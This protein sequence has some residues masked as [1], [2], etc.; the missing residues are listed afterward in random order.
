M[1]SLGSK[2]EGARLERMQS[3]P[4]WAGN[5]FRNV[6][7]I[8][9]GL[10]DPNAPMPSLSDF[11]CGGG[12]QSAAQAAAV[13]GS[14]RR[15]GPAPRT[16]GCAPPGS[17]TRRCWSRSTGCAVLT[18]PVWGERAS[19]SR[20][21]GPKRFQ[22]VPVPICGAAA[23]RRGDHLAR[24]LRSPRLPDA[25]SRSPSATCPS[26]RRS[27]SART[28]RA[29]AFRAERIVELDWW[30]SAT[31]PGAELSI[32]A[33]PS[34][35]LLGARAAA[36]HDAVVVVRRAHGAP[37]VL[38]QRR[39][40]ADARVRDDRERLGPF[41]LVM[42]EVGAFHPTL[43]RHPPRARERARGARAARRRR[44]SCPCTG[45]PSTSRST[46]GTIPPRRC[47]ALGPKQGAHLVMP[48]LGAPVEPAREQLEPWWRVVDRG[49]VAHAIERPR[50]LTMPKTAPWPLD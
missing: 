27:A 7:P 25:S 17:A 3:S 29:G 42:L 19:P 43:G 34:R 16:A 40:R 11:L 24:S 49:D 21:A 15:V 46:P 31:L 33:A 13:G 18:D 50:D 4:L 39:H 14:A 22:P 20:L 23:A 38:L 36:Q 41:D 32:T 28:S 26:T 12:R 8:L 2:A 35:A 6:H 1:R 10:R 45:A 44:A 5:G 47:I 9:P 37:L 48:R 30:E